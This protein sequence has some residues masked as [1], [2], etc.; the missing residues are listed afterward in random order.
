MTYEAMEASR[1]GGRPVELYTFVIGAQTYRYT[2]AE[3]TVSFGGN[4]YL[5]RPITRSSPSEV[6]SEKPQKLT[7][8]INADDEVPRRYIGVPPGQVMTLTISRFHRGDAG[9]FVFWRGRVLGS[10]FV[11]G[12]A[13]AEMQCV[14]SE[15]SVDRAIPRFKF[16]GLCNHVLYDAR[17]GVDRDLN[18]HEGTVTGVAGN[19]LTISGLGAQG[20]GWAIGGMVNYNDQDYRIAL[21]QSGDD[22]TVMIPF[23]EDV[24]GQPVTV[25]AGC[26]HSIATCESKFSN[27]VNH[28]GFPYVPLKNPFV[29]GL[30]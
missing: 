2:S 12:G 30:G 19:V 15:S 1:E 8:Q 17:C 29:V 13:R 28:G 7:L 3:D 20:V 21:A 10:R 14:S 11:E 18:K 16:Q 24:S 26:D 22:V 6:R 5:S 9:S 23:E 27:A 25:Y 4:D